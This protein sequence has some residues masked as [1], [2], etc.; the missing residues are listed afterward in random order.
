MQLIILT[1]YGCDMMVPYKANTHS[2]FPSVYVWVRQQEAWKL[3][4]YNSD[5]KKSVFYHKICPFGSM[6]NKSHNLAIMVA[7]QIV[8]RARTKQVDASQ[9]HCSPNN[10]DN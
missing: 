8:P 9:H 7:L 10:A 4:P 5:G 2:V 6:W 1:L 3:H